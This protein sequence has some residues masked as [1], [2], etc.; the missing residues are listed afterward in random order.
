GWLEYV[1]RRILNGHR[2]I[3]TANGYAHEMSRSLQRSGKTTRRNEQVNLMSLRQRASRRRLVV[4]LHVETCVEIVI[5]TT[6]G[7]RYFGNQPND[8]RNAVPF[9]VEAGTNAKPACAVE[10]HD[11]ENKQADDPFHDE[12]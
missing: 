1:E 4:I 11:G 8:K 6:G 10:P 2:L 12:K 3:A 7:Y 5:A 9:F